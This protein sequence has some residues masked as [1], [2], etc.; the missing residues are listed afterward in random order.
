MQMGFTRGRRLEDNLFM[1]E[2]CRYYLR[3]EE[4]RELAVMENKQLWLSFLSEIS[5]CWSCT[6]KIRIKI[7]RAFSVILRASPATR[8]RSV[9]Q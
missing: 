8:R 2:W 7:E 1:L 6:E 5:V 3:S 4:Y 9:Q